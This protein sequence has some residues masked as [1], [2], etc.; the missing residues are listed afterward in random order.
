MRYIYLAVND[1]NNS[2]SNTYLSAFSNWG[3]NNILARI[4]I[5][6]PFFNVLMDNDLSQHLEPRQY[7]G[8]VDIQK[9]HIQ[10]LDDHGR[11]LEMNKSNYTLV[12]AFK[13]LYD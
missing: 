7:F 3:N 1:F 10:I 8:P 11:I 4:P 13:T 6:G 5:N 2:A 9:L 12:L